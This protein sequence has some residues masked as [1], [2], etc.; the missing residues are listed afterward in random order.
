MKYRS[1]EYIDQLLYDM[2]NDIAGVSASY[3]QPMTEYFNEMLNNINA[4]VNQNRQEMKTLAERVQL[5]DAAV[6]PQNTEE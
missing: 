5:G 4:R 6:P 1:Y 3:I 2:Q